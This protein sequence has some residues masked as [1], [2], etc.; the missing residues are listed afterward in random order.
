MKSR[1]KLLGLFILLITSLNLFAE[2]NIKQV[3]IDQIDAVM[4]THIVANDLCKIGMSKRYD[5]FHFNLT[6][7]NNDLPDVEHNQYYQILEDQKIVQN[8]SAISIH[9]EFTNA[10]I[11]NNFKPLKIDLKSICGTVNRRIKN[12]NE[13]DMYI[14]RNNEQL[15]VGWVRQKACFTY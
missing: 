8:V 14:A 6:C 2:G 9:I 3:S 10:A 15:N 13:Y 7:I 5:G 1:Y 4:N 12:M 11:A